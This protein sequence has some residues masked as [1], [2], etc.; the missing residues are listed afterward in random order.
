MSTEPNPDAS[1]DTVRVA[2]D[3]EEEYVPVFTTDPEAWW[4]GTDRAAGADGV[5]DI[6]R[7]QYERWEAARAAMQ[8]AHAEMKT[9]MR[10]RVIQH[11]IHFRKQMALDSADRIRRAQEQQERDAKNRRALDGTFSPSIR[12]RG[13]ASRL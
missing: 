4:E 9:L 10:E 8:I 7:E 5:Y 13:R 3:D 12:P 6:P 11:Q 2:L 1:T